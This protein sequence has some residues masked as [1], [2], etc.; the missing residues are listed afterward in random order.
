MLD[1][2]LF[3]ILIAFYFFFLR[4][5]YIMW[6]AVPKNEAATTPFRAVV[7]LLIPVFYYYWAF[8]V[9][10]GWAKNVNRIIKRASADIPPMNAAIAF[11]L[12][13]ALIIE[14]TIQVS[15]SF[16]RFFT[17]DWFLSLFF[18]LIVAGV[19]VKILCILFVAAA[20]DVINKLATTDIK[21]AGVNERAL[22]NEEDGW[23]D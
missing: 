3:L 5:V 16:I 13:G 22:I 10:D 15:S 18:A 1:G 17:G 2:R 20:S 11:L 8:I 19:V 21:P 4:F 12:T 6:S 7:L 9:F 14:Y 23:A